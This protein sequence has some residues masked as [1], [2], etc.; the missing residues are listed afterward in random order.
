MLNYYIFP[1]YQQLIVKKMSLFYN[2]IIKLLYYN[3][4]QNAVFL[5]IFIVDSISEQGEVA[6]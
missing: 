6:L 4:L 5:F 1:N 3:H 2:A